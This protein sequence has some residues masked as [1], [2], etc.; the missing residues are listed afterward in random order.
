MKRALVIVALCGLIGFLFLKGRGTPT[1]ELH[2]AA[3]GCQWTLSWRGDAAAPEPL[4]RE[5]STTLEKWEQVLS[6]WRGVSDLSRYN[7]GEAPS[8]ELSRVLVLADGMKK[9]TGGA[10]DHHLLEKVHAA[11]FGPEGKGVDLSSIG[12][13][14]A[15]DRVGERLR[16]LG[17][18]DFVFAIAGEVVAGDGEWPVDIERPQIASRS[19]EKTVTLRNQA[20]ATS[21]NYRQFIPSDE[22]LRT[23]II[24]PKTGKS[25]L[26]PP[27]SVTV[28]APDCASA[29]SWATALF[30]LGPEFK[31]YPA[32]LQVSWQ[33]P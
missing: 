33:T 28:I 10:F 11:G 31:D 27:S 26:R 16:E 1:K 24:D 7:R 9:A 17:V 18:K 13:G 5:V 3:M 8:A 4:R 19:I 30:V 20:I 6:Q 22:G 2:G 25:V 12:K 21:G 32:G 14:F 23:H 15:A 29:S